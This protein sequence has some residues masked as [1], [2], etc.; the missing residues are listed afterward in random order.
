V[1]EH[2]RSGS[3]STSSSASTAIFGSPSLIQV[4]DIFDQEPIG[5]KGGHEQ[6]IDPVTH[7]LAYRNVLSWGR[8]RMASHHHSHDVSKPSPRS[9]HPPSKSSTT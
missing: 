2:Q 6:F 5:G 3:A 7:A 4:Q 1:E 9:S 8:S